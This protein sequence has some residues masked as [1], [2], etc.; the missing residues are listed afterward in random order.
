MVAMYAK[1][2]TTY[3]IGKCYKRIKAG[4][5][6]GKQVAKKKR[7]PMRRPMQ[8]TRK[9]PNMLC[10]VTEMAIAAQHRVADKA[11]VVK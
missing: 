1:H 3:K 2:V 10:V 6:S 5:S 9:G 11:S 4:S 8:S 7:Q